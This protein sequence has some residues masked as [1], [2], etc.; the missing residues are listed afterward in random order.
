MD[1]ELQDYYNT[2]KKFDKVLVDMT[3]MSKKSRRRTLS[4]FDKSYKR[5]AVVFLTDLVTNDLRNNQRDGKVISK[6][7]VEKMMRSFYPPTFEVFDEIEY[8]IS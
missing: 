2:A 4:H 6:E 7:V 8:I 5:K 3:H 1:K